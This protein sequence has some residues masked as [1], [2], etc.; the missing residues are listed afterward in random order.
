MTNIFPR[1]KYRV[2]PAA[3]RT[4]EGRTYGS[5]SEM[6]FAI[7]LRSFQEVGEIT[8]LIQQPRLWLGVPENVYVP[9]FFILWKNGE[10][11]FV[12]VKGVETAKFKRDKKLWAQYGPAKLRIVRKG[13]TAEVIHPQ[14]TP[15]RKE[16]P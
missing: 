10:A 7:S 6:N 13:K 12:D 5:K 11:E 14:R 9:D 2:A 1:H 16:G 3:V 4:W 8:I 15:V